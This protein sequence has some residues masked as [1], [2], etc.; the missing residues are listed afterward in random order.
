MQVNLSIRKLDDKSI[1]KEE[2]KFITTFKKYIGTDFSLLPHLLSKNYMYSV[3]NYT[4]Y[5]RMLSNVISDANLLVLD[6]DHTG[7]SMQ[8]V[9]SGLV[10]EGLQV[11]VSTTSNRDNEYKYRVLLPLNRE[12]DTNEYRRLMLGVIE[13][14]LVLDVDTVPPVQIF[15]SYK[16]SKVLTNFEGSSL[17][18][19]DYI[20]DKQAVIEYQIADT[21][22]TKLPDDFYKEFRSFFTAT[23]GKRTKRLARAG[24]L[25]I[26]SG[27]NR[28]QVTKG[29]L[30]VN[31]S[32][33]VPKSEAEVQRLITNFILKQ[34]N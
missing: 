5:H 7:A 25:M 10:D 24:Y 22:D 34:R 18:V 2:R 3:F 21:T 1:G 11:I 28:S 17:V 15:Y 8:E 19:D 13:N 16:D 27:Y 4:G 20:A 14:G 12:V 33:L 23:P 29:V 31:S 6:V 9:F 30:R 32:L 26:E